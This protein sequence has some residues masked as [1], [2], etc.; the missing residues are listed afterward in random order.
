MN[1]QQWAYYHIFNKPPG[2][3]TMLPIGQSIV[4]GLIAFALLC[5]IPIA[6]GFASYNAGMGALVVLGIMGLSFGYRAGMLAVL[7]AT[8]VALLP[9]A[10]AV[11]GAV[12]YRRASNEPP[13]PEIGAAEAPRHGGAAV[14][15]FKEARIAADL[16]HAYRTE[17]MA[18]G[19]SQPAY[20]GAA[21]VV[22]QGWTKAQK[23]PAWITCADGDENWCP[24]VFGTRLRAAAPADR[25]D[26]ARYR[27]A[28]DEAMKRHG[29]AE[30][31]GAPFLRHT[32]SPAE[33]AGGA[34][35]GMIV[36]PTLGFVVWL[37]GFLVWRAIKPAKAVARAR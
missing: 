17:R 10:M 32:T 30:E 15:V 21:P 27:F 9:A 26:L 7:G 3:R 2:S 6:L 28:A 19:P 25:R 1:P 37:L 36:M 35:G 18:G 20:F 5:G 13:A 4:A 8:F 16:G 24:K 14:L 31:P 29:L 22:P 12:D 11:Q 23:V 34:L 33:S